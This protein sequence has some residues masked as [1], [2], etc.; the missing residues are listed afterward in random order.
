MDKN[1]RN[2][3][4]KRPQKE[5]ETIMEGKLP[6]MVPDLE[7]AVLGA[8]LLEKN[9]I[10]NILDILTPECFYVDAHKE[11]FRVVRYMY[12][13]G[14]PIDILT[15]TEEL[16][17]Q[18]QLEIVG[19][20]YFVTKLTN[21]VSSAANMMSHSMI[22][23]EKYILREFIK[24]A[25]EL[26][27]KSFDDDA[28]PWEIK[29]DI[30]NR[31]MVLTDVSGGKSARHISKSLEQS[32]E[33]LDNAVFNQRQLG[34]GEQVKLN[35]IPT[36]FI[37]LDKK[38]NGWQK[39]DFIIL[40]AR[41]GMGKTAFVLNTAKAAAESKKPVLIFSLEMGHISLVQRV[42]SADSGV[43][44]E[45]ILRGTPEDYQFERLSH[46][47]GR[48]YDLPI[49]IDDR[50]NISIGM[51]ETQ[52]RKFKKQN[53]IELIIIDYLQ[54]IK[55]KVAGNRESEISD[56]SRRLKQLAKELDLPIIALAQLSREVERRPDKIPQLSDLR[57]S[58]CLIGETLINCPETNEYLPIATLVNEKGFKVFSTDYTKTVVTEAAKCFATGTKEAFEMVLKDGR[59][60]GATSNHKFLTQKGW[61]Q[62]GDLKPKDKIAIPISSEDVKDNYIPEEI[63]LI[64]HFIANGSAVKSQP[65]RY[66]QNILDN[67]LTEKVIS[68]AIIAT[69]NRVNP[70][71]KDTI[72]EASKFRT[73]FFKPTFHLTHGKTSPIADILRKYGLWDKRAKDKFIPSEF[74]Y[75][76]HSNTCILLKS[77]FSGDGTVNYKEKNGRKSLK[78]SYS[79]SSVQL[80]TGIQ[81]LLQRV[82]IVSFF[83]YIENDK[84]QGWYSLYISGKS[85]ME[86]FVK[87]IGF[88]NKRKND[89]MVDGWER[90]K[91][92]LAGWNTYTFNEQ[93]TI[94]Y[95]PIKS[96]ESIGL[97]KVYDIE[98]PKLHNF[99]A[100]GIIVHNS[101][102]QDADIIAFLFRFEYYFHDNMD[103][104]IGKKHYPPKNLAELII[105]KYRNGS[106]GSIPL[107]FYGYKMLFTDYEDVFD[108]HEEQKSLP[109]YNPTIT[110]I[111]D[112]IEDEVPPF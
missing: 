41:P 62:L 83:N 47:I 107:K 43:P 24:I 52:A 32:R 101:L 94:C 108:E 39:T 28:N 54:L 96:I 16:K 3:P 112:D 59:R 67:D 98:V 27:S 56:I 19:G 93:R 48:L 84:K 111:N 7:E 78:I 92:I 29:D 23:I 11:I 45:V 70:Y 69:H 88:W 76:S 26:G 79:S 40:A 64:G 66:A 1:K 85:N 87:N 82:G 72:S 74:L 68:D 13:N 106:T 53:G 110:P 51:I 10:Q 71:Y 63:S 34:E 86:L 109:E 73:I 100:N 33:L 80:I 42:Q 81:L 95:M 15:V 30:S 77:L 99:V 91:N 103:V 8:I 5:F 44:L 75:L 55:S 4:A 50:A 21:R 25:G 22:I 97:R 61:V 17:K 35:G 102:E 36:G 89:I 49:W 65:I 14:Q 104:E 46:G 57:E 37:L 90:S 60:I 9:S 31:L 12:S 2:F 20:A 18:G 38:T 105:A 58:G 6:P